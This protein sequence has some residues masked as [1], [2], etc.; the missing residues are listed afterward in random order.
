MQTRTVHLCPRETSESSKS[1]PEQHKVVEPGQY[2][3]TESIVPSSLLKSWSLK[4][5]G[6]GNTVYLISKVKVTRCSW[7]LTMWA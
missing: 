2:G 5:E 4:Y 1:H 6:L 3:E 7:G